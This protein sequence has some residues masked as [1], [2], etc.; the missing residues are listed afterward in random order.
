MFFRFPTKET[1]QRRLRDDCTHGGVDNGGTQKEHLLPDHLLHGDPSEHDTHRIHSFIIRVWME[2]HGTEV[3][4]PIYRGQVVCLPDGERQYFKD[5]N[6]ILVVIQNC[7]QKK[8][9]AA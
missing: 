8:E 6:E 5:L 1:Q 7:I 9:S 4:G 2:E 3:Q